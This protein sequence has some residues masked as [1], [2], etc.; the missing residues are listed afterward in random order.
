MFV[1]HRV[2]TANSALCNIYPRVKLMPILTFA[3]NK[4]VWQQ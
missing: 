4:T 3:K 1:L 2:S